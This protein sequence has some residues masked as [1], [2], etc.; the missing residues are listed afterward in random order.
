[1]RQKYA[2]FTNPEKEGSTLIFAI[3]YALAIGAI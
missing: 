1:M 2:V 3:N